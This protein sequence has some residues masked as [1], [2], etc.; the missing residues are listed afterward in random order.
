MKRWGIS[1]NITVGIFVRDAVCCFLVVAGLLRR[2]AVALLH[3]GGLLRCFTACF[4]IIA[5]SLLH[6]SGAGAESAVSI[7]HAFACDLIASVL[8]SRIAVTLL[9]LAGCL[10]EK[11]AEQ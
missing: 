4:A 8:L 5:G 1:H 3:F 6:Y 9:C 10:L 2:I 7:L 11:N